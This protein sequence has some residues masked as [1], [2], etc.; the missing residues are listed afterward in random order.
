MICLPFPVFSQLNAVPVVPRVL[1]LRDLDVILP[2][3]TTWLYPMALRCPT[4][5]RHALATANN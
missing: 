4:T 5:A 3:Q 2:A 1:P